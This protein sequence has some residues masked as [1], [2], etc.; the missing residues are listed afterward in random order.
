MLPDQPQKSLQQSAYLWTW[1]GRTL[2]FKRGVE[3][4]AADGNADLIFILGQ[5][6]PKHKNTGLL[7]D[8][9]LQ[10]KNALV[11]KFQRSLIDSRFQDAGKDTFSYDTSRWYFLSGPNMADVEDFHYGAINFGIPLTSG[12]EDW[13]LSILTSTIYFDNR[14]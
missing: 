4:M 7:T 9:L 10:Q 12:T 3:N 13:A 14:N 8:N 1:Q 11:K 6:L 2:Y 5:Y